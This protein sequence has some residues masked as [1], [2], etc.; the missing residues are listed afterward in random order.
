MCHLERKVTLR[1]SSSRCLLRCR[2]W[3]RQTPLERPSSNPS[4]PVP[5]CWTEISAGEATFSSLPRFSRQKH[6]LPQLWVHLSSRQREGTSSCLV[7]CSEA[8]TEHR[9]RIFVTW[10]RQARWLRV[11]NTN[12]VCLQ[13]NHSHLTN[14][15][16]FRGTKLCTSCCACVLRVLW[17]GYA[18]NAKLGQALSLWGLDAHCPPHTVISLP[19]G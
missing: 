6:E 16:P 15:T 13:V 11:L 19:D 7:Q 10:R 3:C 5:G 8:R 14:L 12:I 18:K 17:L 2:V 4:Y 1:E 9:G